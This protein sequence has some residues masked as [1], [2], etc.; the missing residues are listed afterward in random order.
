MNRM[1]AG[2][3]PLAEVVLE[4]QG[5]RVVVTDPSDLQTFESAIS[6]ALK[7]EPVLGMTYEATF[8]LKT[9]ESITTAFYLPAA[10]AVVTLAFPI[11]SLH[12]PSFYVVRFEPAAP[13]CVSRLR[14]E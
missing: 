6:H 2:H 9:G 4:G 10:G 5:R 1:L 7:Q 12:D 3:A 8:R 14:E 13:S 11:H